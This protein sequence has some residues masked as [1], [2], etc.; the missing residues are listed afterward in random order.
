MSSPG[1]GRPRDTLLTSI[2]KEVALSIVKRARARF[3]GGWSRYVC[4][5]IRAEAFTCRATGSW[6]EKCVHD[7]LHGHPTVEVYAA[8]VE[9]R[10]IRNF[11]EEATALRLCLFDELEALFK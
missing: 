11:G 7:M 5:A 6:L 3:E 2:N 10:C 1:F 8:L 4:W 9:R